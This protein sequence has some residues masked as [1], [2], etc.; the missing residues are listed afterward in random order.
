MLIIVNGIEREV[1]SDPE[2]PLLYVLRNDLGL[3]GTRFGCGEGTCG[4]CMVLVDGE[5]VQSCDVPVATVAGKEVRTVEGLGDGSRPH[6][7]QQA[8]I[9]E[10]A[11][12]CGYCTSG[13]LISAC[14]LL[15]RNSG[16][17]R[18]EIG[19]ALDGNLCRCGSHWRVVQAVERAAREMRA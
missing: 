15:E 9:A 13:I 8:F 19:E 14:A 4:A 1:T 6:P 12:Q 18:H 3:K 10:Q 11:A 16:P 7:L 5:P 17:T 2:T